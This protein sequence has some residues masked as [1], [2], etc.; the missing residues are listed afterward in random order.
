MGTD[1]ST[2]LLFTL[3]PVHI[4]T[5]IMEVSILH[6]KGLLVII[7]IYSFLSVNYDHTHLLLSVPEDCF[8]S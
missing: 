5:I 3:Y 2:P 6:F 4:D 1:E 7:S 8:S